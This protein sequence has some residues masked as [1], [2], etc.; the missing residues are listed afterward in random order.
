MLLESC[1]SIFTMHLATL[2]EEEVAMRSRFLILAM[3]L[4]IL[5]LAALSAAMIVTKQ[6]AVVRFTRPTIVAGSIVT[7]AVVFVHDD[8]RMVRGLA[9]TAVYRYEDGSTG[10]KLAEFMCLP[11]WTARAAEFT[12]RCARSSLSG[13]DVLVEYQFKGDAEAHGVPWR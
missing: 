1:N 6:A 3:A 9:C 2:G 4:A 5:G 13:P 11:K 7:G 8:A 10:E 12:V